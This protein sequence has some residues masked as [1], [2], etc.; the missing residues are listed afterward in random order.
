MSASIPFE[1][2][3]IHCEEKVLTMSD[4]MVYATKCCSLAA[5]Y[6]TSL[7]VLVLETLNRTSGKRQ[8]EKI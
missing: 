8:A 7:R 2:C 5:E 3:N 4:E 6:L 1:F